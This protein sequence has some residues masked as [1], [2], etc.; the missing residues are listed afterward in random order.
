MAYFLILPRLLFYLYNIWIIVL[1][2]Y[3]PL[4]RENWV[5]IHGV[6][7][8][9]GCVVRLAEMSLNSCQY[10][11]LFGEVAEILVWEDER[12]FVVNVLDTIEFDAQYMAY[13]VQ[14]SAKKYVK[15]YHGLPWHGVLHKITRHGKHFIIDRDTAAVEILQ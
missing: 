13:H 5:E 12:I 8:R 15:T 14:Q 2:I 1:K 6:E 11:S 9:I 7:Y 4:F 10:Y 3:L